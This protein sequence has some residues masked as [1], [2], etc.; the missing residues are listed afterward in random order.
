MRAL[1]AALSAAALSLSCLSRGAAA[2]LLSISLSL[3]AQAPQR[4]GASVRVAFVGALTPGDAAN[5]SA[6][7]LVPY[8]DGAQYGAEVGFSSFDAASSTARGEA[9]V[10]LSW[11][12][13]PAASL[14]LAFQGPPGDGPTLGRAPP[15][16]ALL[17]N[18]VAL[19][20]A[21]RVPTR[22]V[23]ALGPG[24]AMLTVYFE[25]WFTPLNFYW[26]SYSGGPPGAGVAE[27]IPSIG[28]YASVSL[29][30]MRTQAAQFVQAGVDALVVDWTNN[31]W[32]PG[33]DSW[34]HRSLGIREL[35]NATDLLFGVY[36]GLRR[37]EGWPVPRLVLLLGLDNGPTTP[38]P[39][40]EAELDYI[41]TAYLGNETAGGADSFVVLEG[42]P[43]VII[44]DGSGADHS[45]YVSVAA[46]CLHT[47]WRSHRE[48]APALSPLACA[49]PPPAR[50]A[51]ADAREL[52]DPLDG[53]AAAE[54]AGLCAARHLVLDGREPEARRDAR[55]AQR[56]RARGRD[57]RSGLLRRRGLA[58]LGAGSRAQRRPHAA[59]RALGAHDGDGCDR[60]AAI[61]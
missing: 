29:D 16:G 44:F 25:T 6:A 15:A 32:S 49:A 7:R 43:L 50:R 4:A 11:A 61:R 39:A 3:P 31:C 60:P 10:P 54:H 53:V 23:P 47:A 28:R 12:A 59:R 56:E 58:Q 36:A 41:A 18:A 57:P 13:A 51:H 37:S 55:P 8:F 52:H 33:C 30:A 22:G 34:D 45:D 1:A 9:V 48:C 35:I 26:Q 42:K 2:A 40:L 27:A 17:S 46:S 14:Q 21:P 5:A 24:D 38:L 19:S 20:V